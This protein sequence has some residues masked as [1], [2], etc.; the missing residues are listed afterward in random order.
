MTH[1]NF[2]EPTSSGCGPSPARPHSH[3]DPPQRQKRRPRPRK[4]RQHSG[5][6]PLKPTPLQSQDAKILS[7]LEELHVTKEAPILKEKQKHTS[8]LDEL[9]S[10]P[11]SSYSQD[12]RSRGPSE[13]SL[14][15]FL[16]PSL[17]RPPVQRPRPKKATKSS[18]PELREVSGCMCL[19]LC[20]FKYNIQPSIC[21]SLRLS[22]MLYSQRI[23]LFADSCT[24]LISKY[25]CTVSRLSCNSWRCVSLIVCY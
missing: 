8:H 17:T 11:L 19:C 9:Q 6:P 5:H 7:T 10:K 21:L 24:V 2:N 22:A 20:L 4:P 25:Y 1:S 23:Y 15:S 18:A 13:L 16:A 12:C 14:G 3:D